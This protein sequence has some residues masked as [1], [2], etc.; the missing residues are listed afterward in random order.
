MHVVDSIYDGIEK[1]S[2]TNRLKKTRIIDEQYSQIAR[3]L[4]RKGVESGSTG[5]RANLLNIDVVGKT[6]TA[7]TEVYRDNESEK[8]EKYYQSIFIGGFPLEDPKISILVLL[9]D[10]QGKGTQSA[11]RVAAPLF[12]KIANQIIPY[13]GLVDGD[14]YTIN[15]NDFL[16]LVPPSNSYYSATNNIMPNI[17][18]LSLRDALNNI[19]YIVS[20]NNAK[21]AIQ[22]EGY[23]YDYSP[24]AGSE[25]T[26]NS[27]VRL[28]L[29]APIDNKE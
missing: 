12:A 23:V 14:I 22:G 17:M 11:G 21:I 2:V 6:G 18:G 4:L 3:V 7:I 1:I 10:P 27:I 5:Y 8:P 26:N 29:K 28:L 25:I 9:D 16:S 19:S 15:T 24:Q 13:L 20:N